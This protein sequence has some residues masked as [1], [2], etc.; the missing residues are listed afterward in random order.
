[1]HIRSSPAMTFNGVDFQFK[2]RKW[3]KGTVHARYMGTTW[4][5]CG[6]RL[7]VW[8]CQ[9]ICD[10]FWKVMISAPWKIWNKFLNWKILTFRS[11]KL[12][13]KCLFCQRLRFCVLRGKGTS[14]KEYI[15]RDEIK[16]S[17]WQKTPN[18]FVPENIKHSHKDK[19]NSPTTMSLSVFGHTKVFYSKR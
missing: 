2:R 18:S 9:T 11:F 7:S 3:Y 15:W 12:V 16:W 14:L 4:Q 13:P 6:H 5:F 8:K 1:M 10:N 17:R 19:C